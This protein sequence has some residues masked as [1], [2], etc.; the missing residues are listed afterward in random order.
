[1]NRQ[2]IV[3]IGILWAAALWAV[4]AFAQSAKLQFNL[5]HLAKNAVQS[6]N[7]TL[8]RSLIEFAAKL[9]S[10]KDPEQARIKKLI[11]GLEGVYVRSFEFDKEGAYSLAEVEALRRQLN[12]SAWKNIV[13]VRNKKEA[14]YVEVYLR[15]EGDK[16]LG[17]AVIAAEPKEL[18]VVNI[19]GAIDLEQLRELEGHL[20]IP[21][22]GGLGG[23]KKTDGPRKPKVEVEQPRE[24]DLQ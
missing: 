17:L 22:I 10:D 20:G 13:Q 8:D 7:V 15:Q 3:R 1:M 12:T 4:P 2:T 24:K 14:E 18:T 6:V 5:D 21:R 11:L 19:A 16:I 9:F 23:K